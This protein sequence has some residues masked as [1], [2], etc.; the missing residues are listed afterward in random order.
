ML[1]RL[2]AEEP[3]QILGMDRLLAGRAAGKFVEPGMGTPELQQFVG[4]V[5]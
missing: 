5:G 2:F 1:R 3:G 4:Q